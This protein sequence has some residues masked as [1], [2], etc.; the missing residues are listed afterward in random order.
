VVSN[1]VIREGQEQPRL[2]GNFLSFFRS[3]CVNGLPVHDASRG[4]ASLTTFS[5]PADGVDVL[6]PAKEASKYRD[7]LLRCTGLGDAAAR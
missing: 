4:I 2:A 5:F 6:S 3:S 1:G 7:L